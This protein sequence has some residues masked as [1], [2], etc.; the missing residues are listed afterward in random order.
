MVLSCALTACTTI[1]HVGVPK[2]LALQAEVPGFQGVRYDGDGGAPDFDRLVRPHLTQMRARMERRAGAG[3]PE[4][5]FLALSG[6]AQDGAFGA[7]ILTGWRERGTL[8]TFD[9]VTGVS[10]GALIAPIVFAGPA[11]ARRLEQAFT[12]PLPGSETGTGSFTSF[13]AG[14]ALPNT[15]TVKRLIARYAD[16]DLLDAIAR[17]RATGRILLIGT[18]NIET[19]RPVFWDMGRIA[20]SNHPKR[21]ALFRDV[22]LASASVPGILDPVSIEVEAGGETYDEI[23]VDGGATRGVFLAPLGFTRQTA[24]AVFNR[25]VVRRAFIIR[26]GKVTPEHSP[27]TPT[28]LS[29]IGR[30][31]S[32]LIKYRGN[33]DLYRLYARALRDDIDYNLAFIPPS[34][35]ANNAS[36][37]DTAYL[38]ELF[39][40]GRKWGRLGYPWRKQPPGFDRNL[41]DALTNEV[42]N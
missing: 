27:V 5:T 2:E 22:L 35:R 28:T 12:S 40:F 42:V 8:P 9:L 41:R 11:F 25:Q 24:D 23:H 32:T 30:S 4:V 19:Q 39:E 3:Q 29:L 33:G 17:E 20:A 15:P 13:L 21:V 34:Y 36:A 7:G 10:A 31:I 38:T 14:G 16:E 18:T 26:N 1:A 6:G 37:F